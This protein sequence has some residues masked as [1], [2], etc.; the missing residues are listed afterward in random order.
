MGVQYNRRDKLHYHV[1]G[2]QTFPVTADRLFNF[3]FKGRCDIDEEL[4]RVSLM[5]I[6][7]ARSFLRNLYLELKPT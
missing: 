1:R 2:K 3:S 7:L 6:N 4:K 5:F